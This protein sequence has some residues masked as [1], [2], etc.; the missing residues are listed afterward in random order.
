MLSKSLRRSVVP[1]SSRAIST[2]H[3]FGTYNDEHEEPRFLEMVKMHFDNAARYSKVDGDMLSV[4]RE[5]NSVV[6]FQVPLTRDS[7]EIEVIPCYRAQH[8]HHRLPV[9][10][11]T[12][13][14]DNVDL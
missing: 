14:A 8:S 6:R 4:I 9:K 5:C 10:G 12:R 13:Y 2:E 3:P 7:G 1:L 11:G